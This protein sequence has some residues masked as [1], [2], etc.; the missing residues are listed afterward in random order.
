MYFQWM[1]KN[2]M[3]GNWNVKM[4]Y[5]NPDLDKNNGE[6]LSNMFSPTFDG[7]DIK[8]FLGMLKFIENGPRFD[9]AESL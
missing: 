9:Q 5:D 6:I 4:R 1:K 3:V 8:I 7:F 2:L